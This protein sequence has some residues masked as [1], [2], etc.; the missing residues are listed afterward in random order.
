MDYGL[1][2][3]A[4]DRPGG[5]EVTVSVANTQE[6]IKKMI[7]NRNVEAAKYCLNHLQGVGIEDDCLEIIAAMKLLEI[8]V[9][10]ND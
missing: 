6:I 3:R 9:T 8:Y 4:G 1:P 10:D 5:G 7:I 2:R